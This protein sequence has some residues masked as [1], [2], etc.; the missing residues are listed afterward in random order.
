MTK[1]QIFAEEEKVQMLCEGHSGYGDAGTD[2]VCS[3][4]SSLS[5]AFAEL[6]AE[7]EAENKL[8]VNEIVMDPGHLKIDVID[9][10]GILQYPLR[11]LVCG[12]SAIAEQYPKNLSLKWGEKI[13]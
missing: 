4:I 13:F 1:I 2:I 5:Y 8:L 10:Y 3:G 6:C 7:L 11:M 9:K 12:L